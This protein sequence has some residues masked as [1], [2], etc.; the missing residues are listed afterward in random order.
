MY[1]L[2]ELFKEERKQVTEALLQLA[3]T[4]PLEHRSRAIAFFH[5]CLSAS[6]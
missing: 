6:S 5:Q 2:Q 1:V 3:L 4:H